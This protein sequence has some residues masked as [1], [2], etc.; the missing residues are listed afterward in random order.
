M[1]EYGN[2]SPGNQ[3][4]H[5]GRVG[6]RTEAPAASVPCNLSSPFFVAQK[7]HLPSQFV[8]WA[9]QTVNGGREVER[10]YG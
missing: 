8:T 2:A 4:L 6:I 7:R 5:L 10:G 9:Q 1:P 3:V